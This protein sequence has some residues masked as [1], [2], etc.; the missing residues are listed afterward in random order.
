MK[1]LNGKRQ[2]TGCGDICCYSVKL[3]VR[4]DKMVIVR[5]VEERFKLSTRIQ[6]M[7]LFSESKNYDEQL[8]IKQHIF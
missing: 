7:S 3:E 4:C 6:L 5:V 1:L 8:G 2:Q